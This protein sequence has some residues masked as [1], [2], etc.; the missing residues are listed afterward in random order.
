M[1]S[2]LSIDLLTTLEGFFGPISETAI[3]QYPTIAKLANHLC[4]TR[5]QKSS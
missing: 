1:D 3:E 2:L 4:E 5:A